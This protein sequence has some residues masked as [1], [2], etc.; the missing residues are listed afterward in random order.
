MALRA[1]YLQMHRGG[2]SHFAQWDVT[3]DQFLLLFAL[4]DGGP[5][6][7]QELTDRIT[8]D[9][10]T[11][12]AMVV[13]LERKGL[14]RREPHPT[15]RRAR[16]VSLTPEGARFE[17]TLWEGSDGFRTQLIDLLGS[18]DASTLTE[19]LERFSRSLLFERNP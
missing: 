18:A 3:T 5:G 2:D 8:S 1:A 9:P 10:N 15:D 19:M 4:A 6:T 12:R 13:L 14:V 7:Q 11:L 16:I 17:Q